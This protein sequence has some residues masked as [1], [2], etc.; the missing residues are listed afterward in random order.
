VSSV[1]DPHLF[2]EDLNNA[3][4]NKIFTWWS[5]TKYHILQ[6]NVEMSSIFKIHFNHFALKELSKLV[7][8]SLKK[9]KKYLWWRF[10]DIFVNFQNC[11]AM[12]HLDKVYNAIRIPGHKKRAWYPM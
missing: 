10:V 1:A 6:M 7:F 2:N 9:V 5:N 12:Q 4:K 11:S 3:F 8:F